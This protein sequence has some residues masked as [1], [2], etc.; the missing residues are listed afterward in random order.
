MLY[1]GIITA[2]NNNLEFHYKNAQVGFPIPTAISTSPFFAPISDM[3]A[4]KRRPVCARKPVLCLHAISREISS[5]SPA[6]SF[7]LRH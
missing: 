4:E 2:R 1:K 3:E 7:L 6:Q 5:G